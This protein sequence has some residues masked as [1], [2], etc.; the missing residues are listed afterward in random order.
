MGVALGSFWMRSPGSEASITA[1]RDFTTFYSTMGVDPERHDFKL[2]NYS[3]SGLPKEL[4]RNLILLGKV[5][6]THNKEVRSL[7]AATCAIDI[8]HATLFLQRAGL[9]I[10]AATNTC[11]NFAVGKSAH[12]QAACAAD[13]SNVF[14][15]LSFVA[16]YISEAV[17]FCAQTIDM[18]AR[19]AG[20]ISGIVANTG[21]LATSAA[22]MAGNCYGATAYDK[23][24]G[25]SLFQMDR[26]LEGEGEGAPAI[27]APPPLQ[28]G[29]NVQTLGTYTCFLDGTQAATYL[30]DFGIFIAGA[31]KGCSDRSDFPL[32]HPFRREAHRVYCAM[33]LLDVLESIYMATAFIASAVSH[34]S[35][36]TNQ[37]ALCASGVAGLTGAMTGMSKSILNVYGACEKKLFSQRY[38]AAEKVTAWNNYK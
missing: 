29:Y 22:F 16:E 30:A 5:K 10:T 32:T 34:C 26:R 3:A 27:V 28:P 13:I 21:R 18:R 15:S 20:G 38:D 23:P 14:A 17:L 8:T 9:A 7:N 6:K 25:H 2:S 4:V 33:N 37:Q 19:C 35:P 12:V 36:V 11:K 24:A 31:T 1:A